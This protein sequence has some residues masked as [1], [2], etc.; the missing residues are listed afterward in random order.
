L[1][2][3]KASQNNS[4]CRIYLPIGQLAGTKKEDTRH[5]TAKC[6]AQELQGTLLIDYFEATALKAVDVSGWR[7]DLSRSESTSNILLIDR[8]LVKRGD[9]GYTGG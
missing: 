8:L 9:H 3:S 7:S 4:V 6:V 5:A 2:P 1:I